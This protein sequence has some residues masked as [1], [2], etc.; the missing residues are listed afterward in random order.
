MSE[1]SEKKAELLRCPFCGGSRVWCS[2]DLELPEKYITCDGCGS[3]GPPVEA[4]A[5]HLGEMQA[6]D[7]KAYAKW[8]TRAS[9]WISV[10]ERLPNF[11]SPREPL[12]VSSMGLNGK[13]FVEDGAWFDEGKFWC[14]DA[15]GS[16]DEI[17]GVTHWQP[18]PDPPPRA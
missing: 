10:E 7:A 18:L 8:N 6:E 4:R 5:N 17:F 12:I 15:Y 9:S 11:E 13:P 16:P 1:M 3:H 14:F 2:S